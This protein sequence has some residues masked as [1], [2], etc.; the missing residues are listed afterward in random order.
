MIVYRKWLKC[1]SSLLQFYYEYSASGKRDAPRKIDNEP[2]DTLITLLSAL[3]HFFQ[4]KV[5]Y[6]LFSAS[7]TVALKNSPRDW[8]LSLLLYEQMKL[9]SHWFQW[10]SLQYYYYHQKDFF[11]QFIKIFCLLV[12]WRKLLRLLGLSLISIII[13]I[14]GSQ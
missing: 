13:L 10:V 9:V 8:M 5:A 12:K 4:T 14:R 3:P 2:C 11:S 1:L 7:A 6:F